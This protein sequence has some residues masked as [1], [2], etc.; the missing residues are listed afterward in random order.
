MRRLTTFKKF[1]WDIYS[2]VANSYTRYKMCL[3][4]YYTAYKKNCLDLSKQRNACVLRV[5]KFG[6][7][8]A[9]VIRRTKCFSYLEW[10]PVV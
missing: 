10:L 7:V 1:I 8:N 2:Y 5:G 6:H 9:E 4:C 3:L